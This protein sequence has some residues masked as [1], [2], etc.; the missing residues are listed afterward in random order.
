MT[1]DIVR[2]RALATQLGY[3][4]ATTDPESVERYQREIAARSVRSE[5]DADGR[6]ILVR[7]RPTEGGIPLRGTITELSVHI[8]CGQ[9]RGPVYKDYDWLWQSCPH[10][11][12]PQKWNGCDVS[13]QKDLCVIC[14]RGTAGGTSR[15]AW[16]ACKDCTAANSSLAPKLG[17]TPFALGRHSLMNGIGIRGGASQSEQERQAARLAE[18]SRHH[19]ALHEWK[20]AEFRRLAKVFDADAD[21]PLRV[22]QEQWPPGRE[23]SDDAIARMLTG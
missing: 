6:Y 3:W 19:G 5:L 12:A 21:V 7:P 11:D 1:F 10:E 9:L 20:R 16:I 13:R 18:F 15:W 14:A 2:A 23:A 17:Y 8:P 4:P 22:W